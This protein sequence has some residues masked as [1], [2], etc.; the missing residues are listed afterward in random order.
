MKVG[1]L[2]FT[3]RGGDRKAN[4]ETV[5]RY[6]AEAREHRPEVLVLPEMWTTGYDLI[7]LAAL[8]DDGAPYGDL[9][10]RWASETG[11]TIV[12]GSSPV[13]VAGRFANTLYAYTPEGERILSYEKAHLFGLMGEDRYLAAGSAAGNFSIGEVPCGAVICYDLRFPEWIRKTV[14]AGCEI[15]FIPAQWPLSRLDHWRILLQARAIENQCYVVACNRTGADEK[16]V[17][18]AGHSMVIDPWGTPVVEAGEE[19]GWLW[20]EIEREKVGRV[21]RKMT[22]FAD[23]RVDLY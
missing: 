15:L 17:A 9:L 23:R 8:A 6:M 14:L 5:A 2:Q 3:V 7:N 19:E 22:V 11:A 1:L 13:G 16:G 18:F 20:A 10:V 4:E 21:R 12:G